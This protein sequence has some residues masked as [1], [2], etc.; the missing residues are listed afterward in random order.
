MPFPKVDGERL[1]HGDHLCFGHDIYSVGPP[2]LVE[3]V[4]VTARLEKRLAARL[5]TL[6]AHKR[7]SLGRCLEEILLHTDEPL[8]NTGGVPSPH[9][10]A[11][12]RYIQ[13]LKKK[14]GIDDDSDASDRFVEQPPSEP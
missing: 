4:D 14:H 6:A 1:L 7:T 11:Q 10:T 2:V 12:L 8:G 9:T 13:E 5:S 3:R